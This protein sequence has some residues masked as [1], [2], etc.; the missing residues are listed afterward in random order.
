MQLTAEIGG[1]PIRTKLVMVLQNNLSGTAK[2]LSSA[3]ILN[4]LYFKG[5]ID[6]VLIARTREVRRSEK[7]VF[8]DH[9]FYCLKKIA[10]IDEQS[11]DLLVQSSYT[12]DE[13]TTI[14]HLFPRAV[15]VKTAGPGP[16]FV[17]KR[18]KTDK[19]CKATGCP[20]SMDAGDMILTVTGNY[21]GHPWPL[22]FCP[23]ISCVGKEGGVLEAAGVP[24]Y[25]RGT[26]TMELALEEELVAFRSNAISPTC[27]LPNCCIVRIRIFI[28]GEFW[29]RVTLSHVAD[30]VGYI[31]RCNHRPKLLSRNTLFIGSEWCGVKVIEVLA[32]CGYI[33]TWN[34]VIRRIF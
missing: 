18:C 8:C 10:G 21:Q 11:T 9:V 28:L 29:A 5:S 17:L 2:V 19:K 6:R 32:R 14:L 31:W 22:Y 23:K 25:V 13:F 34:T 3:P 16:K 24:P 12:D 33:V 15:S 26:M 7:N 4:V 30:E 20:N 1:S 27:V